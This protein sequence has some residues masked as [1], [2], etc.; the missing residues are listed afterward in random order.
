MKD[1]NSIPTLQLAITLWPEIPREW[2]TEGWSDRSYTFD[3][4]R[5]N[6]IINNHT[7]AY[8]IAL[9]SNRNDRHSRHPLA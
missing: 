9:S 6:F 4:T 5:L 3:G 2:G 1:V 7:K 8:S